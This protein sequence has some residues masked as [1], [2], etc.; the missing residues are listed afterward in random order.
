MN[1]A[2]ANFFDMKKELPRLPKKAMRRK[3]LATGLARAYRS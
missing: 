1:V 3:K 2:G